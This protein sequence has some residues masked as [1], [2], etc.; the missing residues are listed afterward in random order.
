MSTVKDALDNTVTKSLSLVY[1]PT[2]EDTDS[3]QPMH[4]HTVTFTINVRENSPSFKGGKSGKK[5]GEVTRG[6]NSIAIEDGATAGLTETGLVVAAGVAAVKE[7]VK[8]AAGI[9]AVKIYDSFTGEGEAGLEEKIKE[10]AKEATEFVESALGGANSIIKT[11]QV[12]SLITQQSPQ[13]EYSAGWTDVEFGL[14]GA[15]ATQGRSLLE[16]IRGAATGESPEARERALRMLAGVANITQAAGFN[17]KLQDAIELQSGKIPNPYREQLFKSMNFRTF[18]YQFKFVPKNAGEL[19]SAYNVINTFRKNMHPE[20]END[21]FLVY[22]STFSIEYQYRGATNQYLT[23]IADCALTNMKVDYGAGGSLTSFKDLG[24]APTEITMTLQFKELELLTRD[25]FEDSAT[26]GR[27]PAPEV[28]TDA[29]DP[30]AVD[31]AAD[32]DAN[33]H[34]GSITSDTPMEVSTETPE[35]RDARFIAEYKEKNAKL[36][37]ELSSLTNE[38][39]TIDRENQERY[40]EILDAQATNQ[41]QIGYLEGD[42]QTVY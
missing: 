37:E 28:V 13:E 21:F 22:P 14:A 41:D 3:R 9:T 31:G 23:K 17:F 19:K 1:P 29:E 40:F 35:E 39:G 38:D 16:D 4:V 27:T 32:S 26:G 25:W 15:Y 36:G 42:K 5:V 33:I 24:G 18:A 8:A 30:D 12:I 10:G 20:R 11:D 34:P 6:A 2:P 7:P